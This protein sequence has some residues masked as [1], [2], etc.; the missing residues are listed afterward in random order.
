MTCNFCLRDVLFKN[1]ICPLC[2]H[3]KN[4]DYDKDKKSNNILSKKDR[5]ERIKEVNKKGVYGHFHTNS[6]QDM[7]KL[8]YE[9]IDSI[10]GNDSNVLTAD[11]TVEYF[12]KLLK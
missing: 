2:Q 6:Q 9:N 8:V 10:I 12:R 7:I 4:W 5:N 1:N 11:E 3:N